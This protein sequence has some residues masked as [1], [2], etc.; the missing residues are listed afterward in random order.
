[1]LGYLSSGEESQSILEGENE[2]SSQT[3]VVQH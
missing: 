3:Q 2:I 1:M